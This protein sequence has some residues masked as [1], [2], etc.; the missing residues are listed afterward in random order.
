MADKVVKEFEVKSNIGEVSKDAAGLASEFKFMG[1]SVNGVKTSLK[2]M[3][4]TAK[5]S[6]ATMKAAMISTGV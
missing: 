3:A 2:A 5:A 4:T 1:V 6:F